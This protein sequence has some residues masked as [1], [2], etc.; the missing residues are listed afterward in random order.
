[1]S[2]QQQLV[3][4]LTKIFS[5]KI[6]DLSLNIDWQTHTNASQAPITV[7]LA[8]LGIAVIALALYLGYAQV[9][10]AQRGR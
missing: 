8:C 4:L 10:K 9:V 7:G 6:K 1:M 2:A 5:G 3:Q